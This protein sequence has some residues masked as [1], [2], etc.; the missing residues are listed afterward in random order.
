MDHVEIVKR[1][2]DNGCDTY[3]VGGG[4]RDLLL[5]KDP[6][7]FDIVTKATPEQIISLFQDCKIKQVGK[8]FGV[9][10]VDG[11]E[12]ATFRHDIYEGEKCT[13]RF[14][15]TIHDDLERRD[16]TVNA[17][18]YCELTGEL[19]DDHG[20]VKD[21]E[22][23]IIRFVGNPNDRIL[24]DP[25]RIIRACR[26]VAKIDGRFDAKTF[27]ALKDRSQHLFKYGIA[28][29]RI[30][31]EI[32]KAMKIK[33]ASKFFESLREIGALE[34]IFPTMVKCWNHPHG[35]HHI[36][37]VWEHLMLA[38]DAISTK[39]PIVKLAGYLHDVG[40]PDA[41]DY[42]KFIGHEKCGSESVKT[43]LQNLRFTS[44]EVS[45]ISGLIRH[46]M[47]PIK[48]CS[49]KTLRKLMAKFAEAGLIYKDFIRLRMA[50]R[51]ANIARDNFTLR[52]WIDMYKSLLTC[53]E[54]DIPFNT[55]R[56]ALSGGEI[57]K[58]FGIKPGKQVGDIQKHLL[59]FVIE[60]GQEFNNKDILIKE[61]T[62]HLS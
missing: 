33:K 2:C 36:E 58:R 12:V 42:E 39:Y 18:A 25:N 46:H 59:N 60:N 1:L 41:Y 61:V 10:L 23:R 13:V 49:K 37:D 6:D 45:T 44:F 28:P 35:K 19:I 54:E 17:M 55:H 14:A 51:Q 8:S 26:F 62:N 40:K 5:G 27:L 52:E 9:I 15:E 11:I 31:L 50:D 29:E 57:I 30:R 47:N 7:D 3:V 34:F 56:L 32:L 48:N 16:L 21:L 53:H 24:E 43:E 20:G 4:I 22:E 38:G